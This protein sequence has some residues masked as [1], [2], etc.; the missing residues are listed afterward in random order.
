MPRNPS[1]PCQSPRG[2][3]GSR[4]NVDPNNMAR[5]VIKVEV[6]DLQLIGP[7]S[8]L[9]EGRLQ[10]KRAVYRCI[11]PGCSKPHHLFGNRSD[12][13]R[14]ARAHDE[15][16]HPKLDGRTREGRGKAQGPKQ[17]RVDNQYV[18]PAA[19]VHPPS[20]VNAP[21]LV[22]SPVTA[23]APWFRMSQVIPAYV[24]SGIA[25]ENS[26]STDTLEDA[27]PYNLFHNLPL[28]IGDFKTSAEYMSGGSIGSA[29][30]H[31][32]M[33]DA[34]PNDFWSSTPQVPL[35]EETWR[36]PGFTSTS[37]GSS[38]NLSSTGQQYPPFSQNQLWNESAIEGGAAW[39]FSPS[40]GP[41][42]YAHPCT[43]LPMPVSGQVN[44]LNQKSINPWPN[45][46]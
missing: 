31:S 41:E 36:G 38:S 2:G 25:I 40:D 42:H 26:R 28:P 24:P 39:Q 30:L 9:V 29:L 46:C 34:N 18:A 20:I 11:F 45:Y 27:M 1:Q 13:T 43:A 8:T 32:P 7:Y 15:N 44:D 16:V 21:T 6:P 5:F 35:G 22:P 14:H 37:Q 3:S 4:A 33:S 10:Q 23:P 17:R 19:S 12:A